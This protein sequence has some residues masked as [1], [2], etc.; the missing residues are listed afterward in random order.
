MYYMF[1]ENGFSIPNKN[2]SRYYNTMEKKIMFIWFVAQI[3][4]V[5]VATY[6]L[7][8]GRSD[9]AGD[10]FGILIPQSFLFILY[11]LYV[12]RNWFI[13]TKNN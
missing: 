11:V 1:L 8:N 2:N 10:M 3:I 6:F 9:I 12:F 13:Q 5:F 7:V 4:F